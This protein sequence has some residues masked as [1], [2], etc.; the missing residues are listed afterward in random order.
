MSCTTRLPLRKPPPRHVVSCSTSKVVHR[1]GP[2]HAAP[3]PWRPRTPPHKELA[4]HR[5]RHRRQTLQPTKGGGAKLP[6][7]ITVAPPPGAQLD[8]SF[9][10]P[11]LTDPA[12]DPSLKPVRSV[13]GKRHATTLIALMHTDR[14]ALKR[15]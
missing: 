8:P 1:D 15:R 6:L 7:H 3:P 14:E 12:T 11:N 5:R 4:P 10:D 2:E 9:N 13:G